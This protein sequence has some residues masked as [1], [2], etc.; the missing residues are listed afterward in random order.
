[1]VVGGLESDQPAMTALD[2]LENA[3]TAGRRMCPSTPASA[4]TVIIGAVTSASRVVLITPAIPLDPQL[5]D[6]LDDG[7]GPLAQRYRFAGPCVTTA[8]RHWNDTRCGLATRLAEPLTEVAD[9]DSILA[10]S[11]S[12][13]GIRGRCRWFAEQRFSACMTCSYVVTDAQPTIA[14]PAARPPG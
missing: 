13:C 10:R 11:L 4:A 9:G 1:M 7:S 3:E 12:R 5:L 14:R 8:C 2:P 6:A